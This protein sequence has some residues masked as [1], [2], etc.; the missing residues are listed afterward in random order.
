MSDIDDEASGLGRIRIFGPRNPDRPN[1]AL[2]ELNGRTP[3][4]PANGHVPEDGTPGAHG[5]RTLMLR[6]ESRRMEFKFSV[7]SQT[8]V[9]FTDPLLLDLFLRST[10]KDGSRFNIEIFGMSAKAMLLHDARA[11][12][13][14]LWE[15]PDTRTPDIGKYA[16]DQIIVPDY[17]LQAGSLQLDSTTLLPGTLPDLDTSEPVE[18]MPDGIVFNATVPPPDGSAPISTRLR[19]QYVDHEVRVEFVNP[20]PAES[21]AAWHRVWRS[22]N[23]VAAATRATAW[24]RLA[25]S[26][27]S[28]LP[29]L[30]WLVT[31][32]GRKIEIDWNKFEL[33]EGVAQITLADQPLD[34]QVLPPL[35]VLQLTRK[36]TF[37]RT[38]NTLEVSAPAKVSPLEA[39][40]RYA[41]YDSDEVLTF[42]AMPLVHDAKAVR[43][44]LFSAYGR[45]DSA[46]L[47]AKEPAVG[48]M[49]LEDGWAEIPFDACVDP[50]TGESRLP[51]VIQPGNAPDAR[52]SLWIG[53]RRPEFYGAST[54]PSAPW[55]LQLDEPQD[56]SVSLTFK[57]PAVAADGTT[58]DA[59]LSHADI[60]LANF[61]MAVR[62]MTWLAAT[63][64][65]GHDALPAASDDPDA[66][67]DLLLRRCDATSTAAPF[68][69]NPLRI[70]AQKPL[71]GEWDQGGERDAL[72]PEAEVKLAVNLRVTAPDCVTQRAWLRHERLPSVQVMAAT[73]S[74]PTSNR[75]HASRALT[76]FDASAGVLELEAPL[77]MAARLSA[78][79][80]ATFKAAVTDW[81]GSDGTPAGAALVPLVA[82]TLPGVEL[83]P[84]S[85][86][87]YRAKG[88][89]TLPLWDD[90]HA[91]A[92][93]PPEDAPDQAPPVVTALDPGALA[94]L[95][96][97][98]IN[99]RVNASTQ[100]GDMFP[101]TP[102]R[103][104]ITVQ[105][106]CL[107][108]PLQWKAKVKV[109]DTLVVDETGAVRY[110]N[111]SFEDG[112]WTWTPSG[113]D[114]LQ[115]P[116][117]VLAFTGQQCSV[118]AA[119]G[120]ADPKLVGWSVEE[121][122]SEPDGVRFIR[123]GR[124]VSWMDQLAVSSGLIWRQVKGEDTP[125]GAFWL[126]GTNRP[127]AVG[128]LQG[129][130]WELSFTD[131]P[132][133]GTMAMAAPAELAAKAAQA[134]TWSLS[135]PSDDLAIVPLLLGPCL[136]FV[137]TA[138][139]NLAWSDPGTAVS[140]VVVEGALVL[141]ADNRAVAA[142]TRR[143]VTI[144]MT[145]TQQDT[146]AITSIDTVDGKPITWDLD[147]ELQDGILSGAPQ[148]QAMLKVEQ[149]QLWLRRP[150][151]FARLFTADF[152]IGLDDVKATD[153]EASGGVAGDAPPMGV[154]V[155]RAVVNL[156]LATLSMVEIQAVLRKG[157]N[158]VI[159]HTRVARAPGSTTAILNWFGNGI[160][161]DAQIVSGRRSCVFSRKKDAAPDVDIFPGHGPATF[162]D[163]IVCLGFAPVNETSLVL[164][165]HFLELVLEVGGL[166]I[167]HMLH[168]GASSTVR[169]T[170]RFDGIWKQKSLVKWPKPNAVDFDFAGDTQVIDFADMQDV[171]HEAS[172]L[173]ADHC[174]EG[175]DFE[176]AATGKGVRMSGAAA[177]QASTWLVDTIHRFTIAG[178]V[179]REVRSLGQ[180]QFWRPSA[181][182]SGLKATWEKKDGDEGFAFV[183]GYLGL[184]DDKHTDAFLR[185][186]VRR[187]DQGFAGLFDQRIVDALSAG[188]VGDDTWIM[189]GGTT[190][191][192]R[193]EAET[194]SEAATAPYLLLHLPFVGALGDAGALA[195]LLKVAGADTKLRMSRHDIVCQVVLA[196]AA[197]AQ[198]PGDLVTQ[199]LR[200]DLPFARDLQTTTALGGFVLA[201]NWFAER[202][203]EILPGWH[204]EQLQRPG[205][206]PK[207]GSSPK[208][209]P[210]AY[211]RAALMLA[212]LLDSLGN[213]KDPNRETLS[214]LT[215]TR[216]RIASND[217]QPMTVESRAIRLQPGTVM[218]RAEPGAVSD[219]TRSDLIVG[220]PQGVVAIPL[221]EADAA[222]DDDRHFIALAIAGMAQPVFV[223]RRV[224][225][226]G[227]SYRNCP[228]PAVDRDPLEFQVRALRSNVNYAV[229][230][231]LTWPAPTGLDKSKAEVR[232]RVRAPRQYAAPLAMAGVAGGINTAL[233]M[234]QPFTLDMA[235]RKQGKTETVWI[236]EWEHV[237][238]AFTPDQRD[239]AA[240]W[241]RD[242][243]ASARPLVPSAH[244]LAQAL[245]RMD[246]ALPAARSIQ[247]WLPAAASG[248]DF[249]ARAG[250][251]VTMGLR[252][253]RSVNIKHHQFEPADAGPATVRTIRRPRPVALPE[254]GKDEQAWRRPVGWY[255]MKAQTCMTLA[256]AWDS[257]AAPLQETDGKA[258]ETEIPRWL[259][260]LGLPEPYGLVTVSRGA[261]PVWRGSVVVNCVVLNQDSKPLPTPAHL[262]LWMLKKAAT[263][264]HLRCG[265]RVGPR[266]I[267][268]TQIA[269][270][271]ENGIKS[272][273]KLV[274]SLG[275]GECITAGDCTFVCGFIPEEGLNRW[276][277]P[278]LVVKPTQPRKTLELVAL[279]LLV[280]PVRGPVQDRYPL[281]ILRRT[282]FFCDPVFDRKLSRV[283]PVSVN[284]V[285]DSSKPKEV[286]N[287]WI[288]RPSVTP[289]ETA[290]VRVKTNSPDLFVSP[291][292]TDRPDFKLT[293]KVTRCEGGATEDLLFYLEP[294]EEPV[295]TV[296]LW[297]NVFYALPTSSM[298]SRINGAVHPG[299]TLVL[300]V[301]STVGK[302]A[303]ACIIVPVKNRSSLPSPQAIYSL[304]TVDPSRQAAWCAL[305]SPLPSP[306]NMW[307]EVLN[308]N[309]DKLLRR[310]I[311]KWVSFDRPTP[312]KLGYS[313]L[314]A[315]KATESTHIPQALEWEMTILGMSEG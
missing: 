217:A 158:C 121:R 118:R 101:A 168:A 74:D 196:D 255:G 68:V 184:P 23:V 216:K 163:G 212:I 109:D 84:A 313:I 200:R 32:Q 213:G 119:G 147:L 294:G 29:A 129:V 235:R 130:A 197:R 113:D 282:V 309:T 3:R 114:L 40:A 230:G 311:F 34:S 9:R 80:R 112:D 187:V 58:I 49:M 150:R 93:L 315:E 2:W 209:L 303:T 87:D 76:P 52:G 26:L 65:D 246:P 151:L 102:M 64:P 231:R 302:Q 56:F 288:D 98:N 57:L 21:R 175:E 257:I 62:G 104:V 276:I 247:T 258:L 279:R 15:H 220:G 256:G 186:G 171:E 96:R 12:V 127:I 7:G 167:T 156:Q 142:D 63:A 157:V 174:I 126:L 38:P 261:T 133:R 252:G 20:Q 162:K 215:G 18:L 297:L 308:P 251:F 312:A 25:F 137:P 238:Y 229:D 135:E 115:G 136:R 51:P 35:Q 47:L 178:G 265:L 148:L 198:S 226:A 239:D 292:S 36:V 194:S 301:T 123:D 270:L 219:A 128:G 268:F 14:P 28:D 41:W 179:S 271:E 149:G 131:V 222:V 155:T 116:V 30:S 277:D 182:A 82:L 71:H 75:P 310:G 305:H 205:R 89:Y 264:K 286:F 181:L 48:F 289:N 117:G 285:F 111:A 233:L 153:P 27:E 31:R 67:F 172:F 210:F 91:R 293:A 45:E 164:E 94:R 139:K 4:V 291:P 207:S 138:L 140:T 191:L 275:G 59:S 262:V 33:P 154:Q 234:G 107:Y 299:D 221:S 5:L 274:F 39:R 24:L 124:G 176:W 280:L 208:L 244:E 259:L 1:E 159:T 105:A 214:M 253:M 203:P 160:E 236:Q 232:A 17:L 206:T 169:D 66:F 180:L 269:L 37:T 166:Q 193:D 81:K 95:M 199:P 243:A 60:V 72:L 152:D 97:D 250:A 69:L 223:V 287:A 237:S 125:A 161:W 173:L 211:P 267:D 273:D 85:P 134:W 185:P 100:Q 281:P 90:P 22:L 99:L 165:T 195:P 304:V 110:G 245:V 241:M 240:P 6:T 314:K 16:N 108:P 266:M 225:D 11:Q 61:A 122:V 189:L 43:R 132:I 54:S 272:E 145:G 242:A 228:M 202:D 201:R 88:S 10:D 83:E 227:N 53:T 278:V 144:T 146:L 55:S 103:T 79:T 143:R 263:A 170:L 78:S 70:K 190:A 42:E 8:N 120:P 86:G 188:G 224:V 77:S 260:L 141:G 183:P 50:K 298:R 19:M 44:R 248:I 295:A 204:M 307:T 249:A 300:N 254:N 306:E 106:Q 13:S 296:F 290:V 73:R 284:E 92:S 46:E 192:C 283:D 177:S 218:A